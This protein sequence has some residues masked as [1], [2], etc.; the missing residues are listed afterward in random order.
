[1]LK[2]N[3]IKF[4]ADKKTYTIKKEVEVN[5]TKEEFELYLD[6]QSSGLYNMYDPNARA[7]VGLSKTKWVTIMKYY[8]DLTDK[9]GGLK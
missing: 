9:Y 3:N 7:L 8:G 1:L 6:V 2:Y 5:I 4:P